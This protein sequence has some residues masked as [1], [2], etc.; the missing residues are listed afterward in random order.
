MTLSHTARL[1]LVHK[2]KKLFSNLFVPPLEFFSFS[3]FKAEPVKLMPY[4]VEDL[5][6]LFCAAA[7]QTPGLISDM[8]YLQ[9]AR[10]SLSTAPQSQL[11]SLVQTGS[12]TFDRCGCLAQAGALAGCIVGNFRSLIG[13]KMQITAAPICPISLLSDRRMTRHVPP[14]PDPVTQ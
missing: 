6:S 10:P 3:D 12:V 14:G 8:T 11:G 9:T 5:P 1:V 7:D 4:Y 13:A 2:K